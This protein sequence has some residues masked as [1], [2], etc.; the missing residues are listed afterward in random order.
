M[1]M[2]VINIAYLNNNQ[3]YYIQQ[4]NSSNN[5]DWLELVSTSKMPAALK[6]F[7]QVFSIN[8]HA[9]F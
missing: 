7:L 5:R 1:I 9:G 4:S 2:Y 3:P 8:K 6:P